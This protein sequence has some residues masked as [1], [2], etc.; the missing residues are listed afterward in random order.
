MYFLSYY[1]II[2]NLIIQNS[3]TKKSSYCNII[4]KSVIQKS[5]YYNIIQKSVIQNLI[6]QKLSYYNIIQNCNTLFIQK[7]SYYN[8]ANFISKKIR[9]LQPLIN[10]NCVFPSLYRR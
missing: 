2:Q 7:L 6:I 1:N 4:Q 10:F 8:K 5:L 3:Y 9:G